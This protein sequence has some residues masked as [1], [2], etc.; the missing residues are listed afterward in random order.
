MNQYIETWTIEEATE[1]F[2][3]AIKLSRKKID[4]VVKDDFVIG[5]EY[6]F[7]GEI[8]TSDEID[9]YSD[10]FKYLKDK[11]PSIRPMYNKLKAKLES[12]CFSDAKKGVIKDS[13]AIM[14]LKAN[15][16]WSDRPQEE[17]KDNSV[18]INLGEW[19]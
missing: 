14:N 1:L 8:A 16:K 19:K 5:Y 15:Y 3:K 17:V 2:D 11:F 10:V 13:M 9:Q 18:T 6:H 7:L 4:Y 12:N